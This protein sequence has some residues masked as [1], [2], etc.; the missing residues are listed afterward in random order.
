MP[1]AKRNARRG[2][3][4]SLHRRPLAVVEGRVLECSLGA[5]TAQQ[6]NGRIAHLLCWVLLSPARHTAITAVLRPSSLSAEY[7]RDN[8]RSER[9]CGALSRWGVPSAGWSKSGERQGGY[10][11]GKRVV[12][13]ENGRKHLVAIGWCVDRDSLTMSDGNKAVLRVCLCPA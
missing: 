8:E 3:A 13:D 12:G 4:V 7:I 9:P 2:R 1:W 6:P 10:S 5:A 11:T